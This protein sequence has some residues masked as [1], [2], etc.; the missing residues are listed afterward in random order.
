[1][2]NIRAT[3][4]TFAGAMM[5][6]IILL[7]L[8]GFFVGIGSAFTNYILEEGTLLYKLFGMITG[9][10]FMFMN[11][12]QLWFAV[13]I[14]FALAKKEK[15]WAAF[16]GLIMFYC[17]MKGVEGWAGFEG[18][19]ADTTTVEALV[20]SGY[21][22][23]AALNFNALWGSNVGMFGYNMGIFSGL[24]SGLLTAWIHNKF[25][26]IQLP[27]MFAFFA[28]TKF[29]V[30]IVAL[31]S[32]PLAILTYYVWP[33]IGGG[34]QSLTGFISDSGLF[35]TFLFGTLDKALLPFG[36][37]HLIA[38]PIEYSEVGG[39][40]LIDGVMYE[41]VRN[42]ING[43]AASATATEYITRNFTNGR[44]LFQLAGLPGAAFAMYKCAEKANRKKVAALLIPAVFT[45]AM[46]GISEPIEYTFLFVAPALYW[47]VYAP[48]CGICY[49]L[50]EITNIS[51]NGTAL[52]FMIPNLF[53]PHKVHAMSL[54][55]LLPLA[56]IVYYS[57]F[58]F[59]ILK[60]DLQTPGRGEG[61]IKLMSKKEYNQIKDADGESSNDSLET[62]IVEALG[63]ADNIE[64]VTC[65][66]SRLRVIV[67]DD[68]L[69][70]DDDQ[71]KTYLEAMGVVRAKNSIQVIYGVRVQNITTAVKDILHMD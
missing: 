1:M 31:A 16:A 57:A 36:V 54:I 9:V 17:Y 12:L 61:G 65:C 2:K 47:L 67:K 4:Q 33:F 51:I 64:S 15:G 70:A 13:A 21:T 11:N 37:H 68:T 14:A 52:F 46:V 53:Q 49:V 39:T 8:V 18:W 25:V 20:K 29:V 56:F 55:Y 35:G 23:Q 59:C 26:D 43:Q 41:G 60:F 48:L 44:L 27:S 34:L 32:I 3:L 28:G 24:V 66:A 10:G 22:E 40:M 19:T 45:L 50:A 63:G 71:F 62:R 69:V 30:M 38:F 5:V 7:V 58:K 6:P 42:I